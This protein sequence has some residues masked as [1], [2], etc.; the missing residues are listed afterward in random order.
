LATLASGALRNA[1]IQL[2]PAIA[3]T[4]TAE[5]MLLYGVLHGAARN[6]GRP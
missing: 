5:L 3:T 2:K 6:I 4:F 1:L